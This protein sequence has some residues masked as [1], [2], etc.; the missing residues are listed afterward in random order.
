MFI[1]KPAEIRAQD[2]ERQQEEIVRMRMGFDAAVHP[3]DNDDTHLQVAEAYL[4]DPNNAQA[5]QDPNFVGRLEKHMSVHM[6][7]EG[8]KNGQANKGIPKETKP[9]KG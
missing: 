6:Q 2:V 9:P 7:S 1:T 3:N 4:Q 8:M 5:L